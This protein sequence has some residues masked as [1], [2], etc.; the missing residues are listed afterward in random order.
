MRLVEAELDSLARRM[1]AG[2]AA[3]KDPDAFWGDLSRHGRRLLKELLEGTM[4]L[5]RD[6]WVQVGWHQA[7]PERSTYRNGYYPRKR[8]PTALGRL[9]DVRVPRCRD[10]G[11]TQHMLARLEDHRQAFG[12]SVVDML[13]AGVS[14][15]R[16]G[17][18]LERIIDLPVSAGQVSKLAKR[19]DSEVR[20]FHTPP[21]GDGLALAYVPLLLAQGDPLIPHL[22]L[23]VINRLDDLFPDQDKQLAV[24]RGN[25]AWKTVVTP[26]G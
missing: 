17:E 7:A 4:E 14:T 9:R 5:W 2:W 8:W 11:L 23:N 21:A 26:V 25:L 22:L 18:L 15:R 6:E 1:P 12:Q 16:V 19:L 20:A 24:L 3:V 13:L 10:P